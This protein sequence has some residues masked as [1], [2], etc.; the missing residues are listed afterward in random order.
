LNKLF[1]DNGFN[2]IWITTTAISIVRLFSSSKKSFTNKSFEENLRNNSDSNTLL[3]F[4]KKSVNLILNFSGR[5]DS[6]KGLFEK[7]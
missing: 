3:N 2:K 6:L 4:L 7:K 5:G 1:K